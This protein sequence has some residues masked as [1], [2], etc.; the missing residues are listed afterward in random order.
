VRL[1]K[2]L[3]DKLAIS[4]INITSQQARNRGCEKLVKYK[5]ENRQAAQS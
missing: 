5:P 1:C 4:S 2:S 3:A